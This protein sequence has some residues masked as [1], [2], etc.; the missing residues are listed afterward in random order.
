[1]SGRV[2]LVDR[3]VL[4]GEDG[5]GCGDLMGGGLI[6]DIQV[7]CHFGWWRNFGCRVILGDG[8]VSGGVIILIGR[9]IL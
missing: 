5:F 4:V 8:D 3:N 2:I 6:S 1:M 9:V 7:I